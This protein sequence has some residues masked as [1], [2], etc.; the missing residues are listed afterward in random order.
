M[1]NSPLQEALLYELQEAIHEMDLTD[2]REA[3]ICF[4]WAPALGSPSEH[5]KE[6]VDV[7]DDFYYLSVERLVFSF[8]H[9][10]TEM[11]IHIRRV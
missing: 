6:I 2:S 11:S 4:G 3:V 7:L 5:V 1:K 10:D 9:Q 8:D